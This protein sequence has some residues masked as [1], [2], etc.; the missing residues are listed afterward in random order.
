MKLRSAFY[1]IAAL[2]MGSFHTG[3]ASAEDMWAP[4]DPAAFEKAQKDGAVQLVKIHADWCANCIAQGKFLD[5]MLKEAKYKGFK[6]I[7]VDYDKDLGFKKKYKA[8]DTTT[9]LVYRGDTE[10]LRVVGVYEPVKLRKFMD[11]AVAKVASAHS[12]AHA[13]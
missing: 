9:L 5:P 6:T 7:V 11:E 10:L 3:Q 2:F 4:Y 12:Q 1:I 13:D 8:K